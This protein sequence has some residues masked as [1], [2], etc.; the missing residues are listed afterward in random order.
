ML[1]IIAA[2][3]EN[4]AIGK[5]NKLMWHIP[6]DLKRFRTITQGSPVIMGRRTFESIGRPLPERTNIV[7]GSRPDFQP[8]AGCTV[9]PAF[10]HVLEYASTI[11]DNCFA[12]G[13]ERVFREAMKH[14][15][16]IYL[17]VVHHKY[18]DADRFFPAIR[19]NEWKE[20]ETKYNTTD[21]EFNFPFS[22][23]VLQKIN[24]L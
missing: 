3:D 5:N 7:L 16:K 9:F 11:S 1:S 20:I 2:I 12:I 18:P 4:N 19:T 6:K 17:T 10:D 24:T 14:A 15:E 23:I 21:A 22:F 8:P 13:G